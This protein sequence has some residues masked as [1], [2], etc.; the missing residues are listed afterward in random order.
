MA[1]KLNYSTLIAFFVMI[2][3]VSNNKVNHKLIDYLFEENT[4]NLDNVD[5]LCGLMDC[6]NLIFNDKMYQTKVCVNCDAINR[7]YSHELHYCDTI[8]AMRMNDSLVLF[9]NKI[10]QFKEFS[11]YMMNMK[12]K[13]LAIEIDEDITIKQME[14]LLKLTPTVINLTLIL[15]NSQYYKTKREHELDLMDTLER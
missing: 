9:E 10:M 1:L 6:A 5:T 4:P 8:N 12:V 11:K 13:N 14:D 7:R 3:C 15:Y 2:S